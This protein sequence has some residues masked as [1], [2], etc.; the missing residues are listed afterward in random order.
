[1]EAWIVINCHLSCDSIC[2]LCSMSS[3]LLVSTLR[4]N[5][6][7]RSRAA[8]P[9]DSL[10]S[11]PAPMFED[12]SLRDLTCVPAETQT[13]LQKGSKSATRCRAFRADM[14]VELVYDVG[15]FVVETPEILARRCHISPAH[16]LSLLQNVCNEAFEPPICLE[17]L[18]SEDD[19][20]SFTSGDAGVDALLGGEGMQLG[21]VYEV[22]G[23]R[24]VA[25]L[26]CTLSY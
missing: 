22:T 7:L 3:H 1:M 9:H 6:T 10:L 8:T 14:R 18:I 11:S 24:C 19:R 2:K 17:D 26:I 16:T 13:L 4:V 15:A 25:L 20:D 12:L 21:R 23:Q 5:H